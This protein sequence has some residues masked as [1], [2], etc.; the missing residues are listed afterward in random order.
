MLHPLLPPAALTVFSVAAIVHAAMQ[1]PS[2]DG[3]PVTDQA[4]AA[5]EDS[6]STAG[7]FVN[8]FQDNLQQRAAPGGAHTELFATVQRLRA[9]QGTK[10]DRVALREEI[11]RQLESHLQAQRAEL[12]A[13]KTKLRNLETSLASREKNRDRIIDR[14][15]EELLDP[16]VKWESLTRTATPWV[17]GPG[18]GVAIGMPGPPFLPAAPSAPGTAGGS[19]FPHAALPD[20]GL[21]D[22]LRSLVP[23]SSR[24]DL[25]PDPNSPVGW[26]ANL[27]RLRDA[28]ALAK[29][30]LQDA[31][32]K[33]N[34]QKSDAE[35]ALNVWRHYWRQY[36]SEYQAQLR[37]LR[38]QVDRARSELEAAANEKDIARQRYEAGQVTA[39]AMTTAEA[40][41]RAAEF[42]LQEAEENYS[43][44]ENVAKETPSLNPESMNAA[45]PAGTP[46][47]DPFGGS[48]SS[49]PT[50]E[51]QA[52]RP[53]STDSPLSEVADP[54]LVLPGGPQ[55]PD[56]NQ[57]IAMLQEG[58]QAT[59]ARTDA[60]RKLLQWRNRQISDLQSL[61]AQGADQPEI[62]ERIRAALGQ[63]SE[64]A[65]KER[66]LR[67]MLNALQRGPTAHWTQ[68]GQFLDHALRMLQLDVEEATVKSKSAAEDLERMSKLNERGV[69]PVSELHQ[70]QAKFQIAELDL[71]RSQERLQLYQGILTDNP[72][73][74]PGNWKTDDLPESLPELPDELKPFAR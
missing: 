65:A 7:T 34:E 48:T 30:E 18:P 54:L 42:A 57:L 60:F 58:R 61:L 32:N 44:F 51:Q 67:E 22:V 14:R 56:W 31:R 49:S 11:A 13:L 10:G 68:A 74:D 33:N 46:T 71:Q 50:A 3:R 43:R 2:A 52:A 37:L 62:Q 28:A 9:G 29:S 36:W 63:E 70:A 40:A 23:N 26:I 55:I 12:E 27:T 47:E 25:A 1:P 15:V 5:S 73:L 64:F 66:E 16:N 6:Q 19:Q 17:A 35:G 4:G 20:P 69:V 38:L 24:A 39:S 45:V 53:E 59:V 41:L 8:H 72:E 21:Q